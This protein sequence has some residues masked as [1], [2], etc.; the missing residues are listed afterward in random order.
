M[1]TSKMEA[2]CGIMDALLGENGCPWDRQ[3]THESLRPYLLE[4]A[5]EAAEAIDAQDMPALCEE[6][7]DVLFQ[8]VFH[9]TLAEKESRFT[10]DDI[11]D[12]VSQKLIRRHSHIFGADQADTAVITASDVEAIWARNK[13]KEKQYET[14]ADRL[15]AVPK[16]LPALMRAQTVLKRAKPSDGRAECFVQMRQ[17]LD[18]LEKTANNPG[19][20]G[21]VSPVFGELLL[22]M[23][24]IFNILEI[25]AEFSLTKAIEAFI[26]SVE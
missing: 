9:A 15:R 19:E 8:I 21:A 13:K 24:K 22:N 12:G 17:L 26:N 7:G 23:V 5:Y 11:I 14:E 4:E 10:L 25:N 1:D 2:L 6:L 3:Q 16:A 20:S 18:K